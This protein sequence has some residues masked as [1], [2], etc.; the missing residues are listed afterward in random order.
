MKRVFVMLAV[1]GAL[2]VAGLGS[3]VATTLVT[4]AGIKDKTIQNRDMASGAVDSRVVKDK[5]I[6][7]A[8]LAPKAKAAWAHVN[9]D[10]TLARS[11]GGVTSSS[12]GV[13]G[14]YSVNFGRNVSECAY[15]ATIDYGDSANEG[16][17]SVAPR[18]GNANAVF[19]QTFLFSPAMDADM[20]F[21]LAV[22]C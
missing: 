1:I 17:V 12:L 21:Y 8:D 19:V 9:A 11:S 7:S 10:G 22:F 16:E 15:V 4:S 14:Q 3:A 18:D 20:P 13:D 6:Q 5:S 2:L